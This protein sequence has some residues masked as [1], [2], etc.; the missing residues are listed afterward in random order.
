M[1][2]NNKY[3]NIN[4]KTQFENRENEPVS[5]KSRTTL[6]FPY[7]PTNSLSILEKIKDTCICFRT[8]KLFIQYLI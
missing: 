8:S 2:N 5:K 6:T 1:G 3:E 7:Y 4:N